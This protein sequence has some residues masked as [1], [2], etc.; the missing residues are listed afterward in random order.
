M[1][2]FVDRAGTAP[3]ARVLCALALAQVALAAQAPAVVGPRVVHTAEE[4]AAVKALR[5]EAPFWTPSADDV[6]RFEALFLASPLR[7]K[8]RGGDLVS[9]RYEFFG[10]TREGAHQIFV[11]AS[12]E[13][14]ATSPTPKPCLFSLYWD[15]GDVGFERPDYVSGERR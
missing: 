7:P 11:N 9:Y 12:C 8:V 13:A 5:H 14:M 3:S 10:V 6:R 15:P 1:K 4:T 2:L